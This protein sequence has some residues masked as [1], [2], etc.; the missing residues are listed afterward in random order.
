MIDKIVTILKKNDI[1]AW[2]IILSQT[3]GAQGYYIQDNLEMIRNQ[4]SI[5]IDLT[6]YKD[7]EEGENK[8][9]GSMRINLFPTMTDQEIDEK[10]KLAIKGSLSVKNKWFPLTKNNDNDLNLKFP[11]VQ[12]DKKNIFDWITTIGKDL[13]SHKSSDITFNATEIFI[14]KINYTFLNSEGV[15][16]THTK[17]SGLIEL[18]TTATGSSGEE[19]EL[20]NLLEFSDYSKDWLD[21]KVKTQIESTLD[22]TKTIQLP[23]LTDI[24]VI[25]KRTAIRE[26]FSYFYMKSNARTIFEGMSNYEEDKT[27]QNGNGDPLTITILPYLERSHFNK[28]IDDDGVITKPINIINKGK[29]SHIISDIQFGTYLNKEITGKC[30]NIKVEPGSMKQ[31]DYEKAPY[32]EAV[33]FSDFSMD[34]IT[35]DFGSEIRLAYYYDGREKIAVTGGSITGKI[36]TVI[37]SISLSENIITDDGYMGPEFIYLKGIHIAGSK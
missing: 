31:T 12:L 10:I 28:L 1:D 32:L 21:N 27:I 25:I 30:Y 13:F 33:E 22:R 23:I 29:V 34:S 8:F 16:H 15:N 14:S 6:V 9:R 18:V 36:S 37:D 19:I 3:E 4:N 35:G 17:Y 24:P 20:F 5:E 7:F 11:P 26:F 2:K